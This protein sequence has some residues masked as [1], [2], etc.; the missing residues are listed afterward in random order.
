MYVLPSLNVDGTEVFPELCR[1][2]AATASALARF[3]L[4]QYSRDFTMA[5]GS[6]G[7]I[8]HSRRKAKPSENG[9]VT[10]NSHAHAAA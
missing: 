6:S 1:S 2:V 10:Q 9:F 4:Y 7:D 3:K 8:F 5:F